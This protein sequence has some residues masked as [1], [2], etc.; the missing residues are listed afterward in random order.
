[1]EFDTSS[2]SFLWKF[3][4]S[5]ES[6]YIQAWAGS[7]LGENLKNISKFAF[8]FAFIITLAPLGRAAA[9]FKVIYTFGSDGGTSDGYLPEGGLTRDAV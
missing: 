5:L 6:G 7:N 4:S 2:W 1:M 3:S 8:V 9:S